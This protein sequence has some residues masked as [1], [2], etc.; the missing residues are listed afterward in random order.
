[1]CRAFYI[2]QIL[3]LLIITIIPDSWGK[4]LFLPSFINTPSQ[5]PSWFLILEWS[6]FC[7]CVLHIKPFFLPVDFQHNQCPC[8][9]FNPRRDASSV[10]TKLRHR[11]TTLP[12]TRYA[13][14]T[15]VGNAITCHHS[16][17][18]YDRHGIHILWNLETKGN[19]LRE[20]KKETWRTNDTNIVRQ[21]K[22]TKR[23]DGKNRHKQSILCT[24]RVIDMK[25]LWKRENERNQKRNPREA[26]E[27]RKVSCSSAYKTKQ[28]TGRALLLI[29]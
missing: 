25:R 21:R 14:S 3:L 9:F 7:V 26:K 10:V 2:Q 17:N 12:R 20:N 11:D 28:V 24:G 23:L 22:G 29:I 15:A 1:M 4:S 13:V 16:I 6:W 19:N 27:N 8:R 18:R 5:C